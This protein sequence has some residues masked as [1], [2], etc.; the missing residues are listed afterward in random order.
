M[1]ALTCAGGLGALRVSESV[2]TKPLATR[3]RVSMMEQVEL[4][5]AAPGVDVGPGRC[6][7]DGRLDR[8][9]AM[10]VLLLLLL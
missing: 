10:L 9:C 4:T 2:S 1:E 6:R 5:E 8:V 7:L 3:V